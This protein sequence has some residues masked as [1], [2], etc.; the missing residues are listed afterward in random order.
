[1]KA[2]WSNVAVA[3]IYFFIILFITILNYRIVQVS[4][5]FSLRSI[6]ISW[7]LLFN[8]LMFHVVILSTYLI[9]QLGFRFPALFVIVYRAHIGAQCRLFDL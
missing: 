2:S 6:S 1:M 7:Y 4:M 8:D 9:L 5:L 3:S